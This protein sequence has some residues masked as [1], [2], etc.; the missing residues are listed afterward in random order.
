MVYTDN[1][2]RLR[3]SFLGK[4]WALGATVL[5]VASTRNLL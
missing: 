1:V 3:F 2:Y 4:A 5:A